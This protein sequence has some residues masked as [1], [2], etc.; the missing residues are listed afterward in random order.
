LLDKFFS[1]IEPDKTVATNV[2]MLVEDKADMGYYVVK[3]MS[4]TTV[5]PA[6]YQQM[7][8]RIALMQ[9][10]VHGQSLGFEHFKADNIIKR[11]KFEWDERA[12]SMPVQQ[13][14]PPEG[15]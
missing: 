10:Y 5:D 8:G 11:M 12:K 7:K 1:L 15:Y 4:R 9:D 6:A 14:I 2:P 13:D 3:S